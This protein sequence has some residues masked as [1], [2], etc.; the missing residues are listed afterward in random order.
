MHFFRDLLE[1]AGNLSRSGSIFVGRISLVQLQS[2]TCV[3]VLRLRSFRFN[4][5]CRMY[6]GISLLHFLSFWNIDFSVSSFKVLWLLLSVPMPPYVTNF[7]GLGPPVST[8]MFVDLFI[9]S[10]N[11]I[12]VSLTPCL[13]IFSL[14]FMYFFHIVITL[15]T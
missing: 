10:K 7:A 14:H 13:V 4:F 5:G 1:S 2:S 3:A 8:V 11:Q 15:P 6:V 12:F 9:F